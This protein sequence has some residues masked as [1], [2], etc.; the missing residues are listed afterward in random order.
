MWKNWLNG[1]LGIWV[2]IIPFL[3]FS[4]AWQRTVLIFSGFIIAILGFWSFYEAR[5]SASSAQAD[6][7]QVGLRR[8]L[9]DEQ[10]L[11]ETTAA[12]PEETKIEI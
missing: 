7:G 5:L 2:V 4:L 1:I 12:A 3:N 9:V 6:G 8:P 11:N 10:S